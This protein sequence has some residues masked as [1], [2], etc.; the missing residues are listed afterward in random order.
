MRRGRVGRHRP[1]I[2]FLF[3]VC[4]PNEFVRW[5][6]L[7]KFTSGLRPL[8]RA[9]TKMEATAFNYLPIVLASVHSRLYLFFLATNSL[10]NPSLPLNSAWCRRE[11]I[12]TPAQNIWDFRFF[13]AI[14]I[15]VVI[16]SWQANLQRVLKPVSLSSHLAVPVNS[17]FAFSS[18]CF[19]FSSS[20]EISLLLYL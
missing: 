3:F 7:Y 12:S 16:H 14:L 6:R 4:S 10:S 2:F 11:D 20:S 13:L 15:T 8:F 9:H 1:W 18:F 19:S 17:I 5:F